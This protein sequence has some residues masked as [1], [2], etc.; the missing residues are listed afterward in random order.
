MVA[1]AAEISH[2]LAEAGD[3]ADPKQLL[4]YSLLAGR[5]ALETSAFEEALS[6]LERAAENEAVALPLQRAELFF[7][8]GLAQGRLGQWDAALDA[9]HRSLDGYEDLGDRDAVGRTC[10]EVGMNLVWA[11]RLPEAIALYQRGLGALG[12]RVSA[13]RA[14]L[15][16]RLGAVANVGGDPLVGDAMFAEALRLAEELEDVALRGFVLGEMCTGFYISMRPSAA[17]A[18]GLEGAEILQATGDLWGAATALGFVEYALVHR[19]R[20]A[21]AIKVGDELLPLAERIRN[22]SALYVHGRARG[23]LEFWRSGNLDDFEAFGRWD[24][25]FG[26]RHFPGFVGH[27]YSSLGLAAF[28]RGD[29]EAAGVWYERGSNNAPAVVPGFSWGVWF[30][31]LA[32][33]G[34][35]EEAL[36]FFEEKRPEL[37][38][39]GQPNRWTAWTLLMAFTEGLFVLGEHDEPARWYPLVLE[40]RATG[41]VATDNQLGRLLER[42]AGIAATAAGNWGAAEAHFLLALRQADE[43]P[44][45]VERLETRRF[46]AQMLAGRAGPGD[47]TRA[48]K[49]LQEAVE[50]F[51]RLGMRRHAELAEAALAAMP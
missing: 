30:Q 48:Q 4:T 41:A 28:L 8:L 26:E 17:A 16:A 40:A 45:Q 49:L 11:N 33:T 18:A 6:L 20:F 15:L 2:H 22:D 37:P 42:V 13:D 47:Q 27:S 39:P 35:R 12:E 46:Y 9:W 10:V 19:G 29:W 24:L 14:R 23:S 43:L 7:A 51:V 1:S 32:F 5:R 34:R 44:H 25:E 31:Y 36:A 21:E 38:T 3:E 50:G